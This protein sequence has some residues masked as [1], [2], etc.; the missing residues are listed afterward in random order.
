M[1]G[2]LEDPNNPDLN[3][4]PNFFGPTFGFDATAAKNDPDNTSTLLSEVE[5]YS[6]PNKPVKINPV[7]P[8][9]ITDWNVKMQSYPNPVLTQN[10]PPSDMQWIYSQPTP[11]VTRYPSNVDLTQLTNYVHSAGISLWILYKAD[12]REHAVA[13]YRTSDGQ[14]HQS[15]TIS[16]DST[17]GRIT[18][19]GLGLPPNATIVAW[20]HTHPWDGVSDQ[21]TPSPDTVDQ[22]D[23][24]DERFLNGLA[25]SSAGDPNL[26]AYI[27]T[28]RSQAEDSFGIYAYD[29]NNWHN[30]PVGC[31]V[32]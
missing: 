16:G 6:S 12:H 5:V 23:A 25:T 10:L 17:G 8:I 3:N 4:A 15:H 29:R 31:E 7:I 32:S 11:C 28:A 30:P 21:R 22:T 9:T 1:C 18:K 20:I 24:N 13:I 27:V 19:T 26:I 2:D 14:L